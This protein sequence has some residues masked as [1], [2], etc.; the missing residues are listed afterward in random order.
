MSAYGHEMEREYSAQSILAGEG[1]EMG[2]RYTSE[3]GIYMSSFAA[4]VFI[5]GLVTAGVSVLSLLVALAVML[6]S[7]ERQNSGVLEMYRNTLS[8]DYCRNLAMH[9]ELNS[10]SEDIFPAICTDISTLYVKDGQYKKDLNATVTIAEEFFSSIRP[11]NDGRDVVLMDADDFFSGETLFDN[12]FVYGIN[13]DVLHD[14]SRDA[15]YLRQFFALKLYLKLQGGRWPLILLS[16]KPEKLRNTTVDYLISVGCHG[17]SSLIMRMDNEMKIDYEEFL[18]KQRSMLQ[19]DGFRIKAV[20]SS[21][22]DTLR[23]PC[24][25]DRIFKLPYPIFRH[26]MEGYGENQK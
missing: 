9:A 14:S 17:W 12:Q 22:M 7:C 16:R 8:Y 5:S 20:I 6:N 25:G 26:G 3:A 4:T 11:Q 24:L 23:G 2:S 18:S 10:L 19:R 21:Q 1:S 15:K 13:N